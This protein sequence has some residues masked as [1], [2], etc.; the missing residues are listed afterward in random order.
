MTL[1][2]RRA[3]AA[4]VLAILAG[5]P[6]LGAACSLFCSSGAGLAV[7]HPGPHDPAGSRE[8]AAHA[9][10]DR[11][12][13]AEALEAGT[14]PACE[15][16]ERA[17]AIQARAL[18]PGRAVAAAVLDA[19]LAAEPGGAPPLALGRALA[20]PL[21]SGPPGTLPTRAPLVLRI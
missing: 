19:A 14:A 4:V 2:A 6:A 5:S 10:C 21:A 16:H 13:A 12:V 8:P 9:A 1:P 17:H 3:V 18:A 7:A 20:N 15:R 11:A